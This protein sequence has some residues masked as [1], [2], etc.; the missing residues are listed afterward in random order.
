MDSFRI[1]TIAYDIID[2]RISACS[3]HERGVFMYPVITISREVGS[4]GHLVGE[5]VAKKLNIPLIDKEII[6]EVVENTGFNAKEVEDKGEFFSHFD[7]YM[8][9]RFGGGIYLG[10]DQSDIYYAQKKVILEN[11]K[12]GPCVIIGRCADAI[13]KEE[14]I[15]ALNVFIHADMDV[16]I[17]NYEE[18]FPDL[19]TDIAKMMKKKDKGRQGY[20]RFYTE[21]E[22]GDLNN[23]ALA[24]DTGK[25]GVDLC[26]DLIVQAAKAEDK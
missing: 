13:L 22:W 7:M 18:R 19:K 11:A 9:A 26:V 15:P 12:A 2:T 14:G 5:L 24:L 3:G 20:Y 10:D 16:R 23:Y 17:K 1:I 6:I 4:N 21:Q 25:L 8:N